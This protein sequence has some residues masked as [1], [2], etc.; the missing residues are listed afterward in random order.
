MLIEWDFR[1]I[2]EGE[3]RGRRRREKRKINRGKEERQKGI[4]EGEEMRTR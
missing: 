3:E 2:R 4:R 1:G